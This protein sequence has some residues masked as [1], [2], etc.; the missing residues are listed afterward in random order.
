MMTLAV[1]GPT[2]GWNFTQEG[3]FRRYLYW[4]E[5]TY[6]GR[7]PIKEVRPLYEICVLMGAAWGVDLE[8]GRIAFSFGHYVEAYPSTMRY[9]PTASMIKS[10]VHVI[11]PVAPPLERNKRMVD[12]AEF[13]IAAPRTVH[14]H[15][16]SGTWATVRYARTVNRPVVIIQPDGTLVFERNPP[17]PKKGAI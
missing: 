2:D 12:H 13:L 7:S 10:F 1:T 6:I 15:Q 3:M 8:A 11:H 5:A 16:R 14:E 9:A 4:L 17:T